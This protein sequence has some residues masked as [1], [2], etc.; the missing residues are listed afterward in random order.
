VGKNLQFSI[1]EVQ[2]P[3]IKITFLNL[4]CLLKVFGRDGARESFLSTIYL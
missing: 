3:K 1:S 4:S 2:I